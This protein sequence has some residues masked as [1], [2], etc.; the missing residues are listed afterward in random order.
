MGYDRVWCKWGKS[1]L[2]M[3]KMRA[4]W[5]SGVCK[6]NRGEWK[7]NQGNEGMNGKGMDKGMGESRKGMEEWKGKVMEREGN[8]KGK[9]NGINERGM[10]AHKEYSAVIGY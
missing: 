10:W 5:M 9:G 6:R 7:G 3:G 1:G 8:G 4:K 2:E